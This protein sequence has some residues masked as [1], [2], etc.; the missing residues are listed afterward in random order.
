MKKYLIIAMGAVLALAGTEA[1][2]QQAQPV[3]Q[4]AFTVQVGSQR[5]ALALATAL[6]A[7]WLLFR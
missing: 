1:Y 4:T 2:A 7:V 5:L 6:G 3:T